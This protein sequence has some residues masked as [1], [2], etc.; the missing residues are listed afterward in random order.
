[1]LELDKE[2][3]SLR[4]FG[5]SRLTNN[6]VEIKGIFHVPDMRISLK[7]GAIS[8]IF[9]LSPIIVPLLMIPPL[10]KIVT[11]F[12]ILHTPPLRSISSLIIILLLDEQYN[13]TVSLLIIND[14]SDSILTSSSISIF[15]QE[16]LEEHVHK[17]M[18][19]RTTKN[20][21][22]MTDNISNIWQANTQ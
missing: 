12:G 20:S 11:P 10:G 2:K 17:Q 6:S 9:V 7:R 22:F 18:T 19:N 4:E 5:S 15:L 16:V 1:M 3:S 8:R 21:N 13:I 14:V